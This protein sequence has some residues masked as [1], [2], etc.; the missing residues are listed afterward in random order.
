L[1]ED[2]AGKAI[3]EY[4]L[5]SSLF[6]QFGDEEVTQVGQELDAELKSTLLAASGA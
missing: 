1:Y 4:D 6:S 3:F 2:E 5:P